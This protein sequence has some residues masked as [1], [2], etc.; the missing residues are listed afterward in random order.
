ML[1]VF[2]C[3][4]GIAY[5]F[6][7]SKVIWDNYCLVYLVFGGKPHTVSYSQPFFELTKSSACALNY[8]IYFSINRYIRKYNAINVLEILNQL[9]WLIIDL[10]YWCTGVRVGGEGWYIIFVFSMFIWRPS[11]LVVLE[12]TM[13]I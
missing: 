7:P 4:S 13:T 8:V 10:Y 12:K 11:L 3:V 1:P 2:G 5:R 6:L 9:Y